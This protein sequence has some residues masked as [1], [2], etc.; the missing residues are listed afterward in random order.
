MWCAGEVMDV[1]PRPYAT[2]PKGK[3]AL[4]KWDANDRVEPAEKVSTSG[5]KPL[6]TLWNRDGVGAWRM[7]LDPP[8]ITTPLPVPAP[9]S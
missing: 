1:D 4:I 9:L 2:F 6:P 3:S 7:D 8:P 5:Q